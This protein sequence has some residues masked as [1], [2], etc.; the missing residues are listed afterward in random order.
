MWTIMKGFIFEINDI[1]IKYLVLILSFTYMAFDIFI[2][3]YEFI[4]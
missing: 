3:V 2:P 1:L 4:L